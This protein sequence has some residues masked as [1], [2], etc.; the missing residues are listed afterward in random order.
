[1]KKIQYLPG[2]LLLLLGSVPLLAQVTIPNTFQAGDTARASEVNENF[3]ALKDAVE[4]LQS[5][6]ST[7]ETQLASVQSNSAL[8]MGDHVDV[9]A[10]PN[11]PNETRIV[12]SGVNLQLTN[13]TSLA[14]QVGGESNGLGNLIIGYGGERSTRITGTEYC[15]DGAYTTQTTCEGAGEVWALDFKSGSHNLVIGHENAYSGDSGIVA[16][17]G[18]VVNNDYAVVI[19]SRE[20]VAAGEMSSVVGGRF[21]T[22]SGESSSV[23]GGY[24]NTA[25]G[26]YSGVAGGLANEAAGAYSSVS[27]GRGNT[28][29]GEDSS[30]SG[31]SGGTAAA[32]YSS[33]TGGRDNVVNGKYGAISGGYD[34][35][36]EAS[37]SSISGGRGNTANGDYSSILGG[38]GQ[39]ASTSY[40]TIP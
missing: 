19:G 10:D 2:T 15:S 32:Q 33:V 13:G 4:Q 35:A 30:V 3:T 40:A 29:S 12:F 9:V 17:F 7:L 20:S 25:S 18:N 28:A 27:G 37:Y 22:A 24:G 1:M 16:G 38:S 11:Y 36:A 34:G 21:N 31:G 5:K 6:V 26:D 8:A 14:A 39:T 23:R